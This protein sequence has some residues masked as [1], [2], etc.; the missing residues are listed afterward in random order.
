MLDSPRTLSVK[1]PAIPTVLGQPAL[2]AV[3]IKGAESINKLFC[4]EVLLK[5]RDNRTHLSAQAAN[6]DL[7][8]FIGEGLTVEIALEGSGTFVAGMTGNSGM[9]NIGAG[10]REISGII[11]AAKVQGQVGRYIYYAITLEPWLKLAT[12]NSN[13]RILQ[14]K[15]PLQIIDEVLSPYHFAVEKRLYDKFDQVLDYTTQYNESDFTFLSRFLERIGI[16]YFFEHRGGV[17]TLILADNNGAYQKNPSQAY[18]VLNYY[19]EKP[20]IDQEYIHLFSPMQRLTAGTFS[21]R[22][23]DYTRPSSTW[24]VTESEPRSV[25]RAEVYAYHSDTHYVQP[26]AG[27]QQ[28]TNEPITDGKAL[29]RMRMERLVNDTRRAQGSGHLRGAVNAHTFIL[30]KHPT[31]AANIAYLIVSTRLEM[32]DV[33][34]ETQRSGDAGQQYQVNLDFDVVPL[35]GETYRPEPVTPRPL[36]HTATARVV[37]PE[38]QAVWVDAL[39]RVKIQFAWDRRDLNDQNSSLWVRVGD[40]WSGN[41]LGSTFIPR[42]GS[43]VIVA[44]IGGNPDL[45]IIIGAVNNQNNLPA[46]QL[47]SQQA[48]SGIRSREFSTHGGNTAGGRSNHFLFDD[49]QD[50]MQAQ[51]RSAHQSSSI[52]LGYIRRIDDNAGCKENRGQGYEIYT[53]GRGVQRSHQGMLVTTESLPGPEARMTEMRETIQRL[54]QARDLLETLANLAQQQQAQDKHGDQSEVGNAIKAQNA[55]IKGCSGDPAAGNFPE[56]AEPHLVLASPAGIETTTQKSTHIASGLHTAITSG[57]HLSL[58]T[59]KNFLASAAQ[60]VRLFADAGVRLFARRGKVEIQSHEAD[61][62]MIAKKVLQLMAEDWVVINS[63][64]GIKMVTDGPI[65]MSAKE[66]IAACTDGNCHVY[67]AEFQTYGPQALSAVGHRFMDARFDQEVLLKKPDGA[68]AA[69]RAV[70]ILKNGVAHHLKSTATGSTRLQAASNLEQYVVRFK[71]V[72]P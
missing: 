7:K 13:C 58:A 48:L 68:S 70:D 29:A 54:T 56:L 63:K 9:G 16:N 8:Q 35:D 33:A 2:T 57:L 25:G 6:Y 23:Y 24:D 52:S 17:H 64:K 10:T 36:L 27:A 19:A 28:V 18:H 43:E 34:Q 20:R 42:I 55:A 5:T 49:T 41:Q 38:N 45:P 31:D 69:N 15:T 12:Y 53:K 50:K 51:L 22:E 72:L 40:M 21:M 46:W 60:H 4:Y 1:S 39:G 62:E 37:G 30:D 47:P 65:L 3:S 67:S 11:T 44:F 26:K 32:E 61:I 14:N 66:G 71:G 59:G